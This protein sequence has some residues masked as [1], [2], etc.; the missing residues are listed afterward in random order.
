M[1]DNL[2]SITARQKR[3]QFMVDDNM[4]YYGHRH[5]HH[6]HGHNKRNEK[7]RKFLTILGIILVFFSAV[8][9]VLVVVMTG[10]EFVFYSFLC[11]FYLF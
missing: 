4:E 9:I 2:S 5:H 10:N 7:L 3:A 6:H 8:G 1:D 11:I